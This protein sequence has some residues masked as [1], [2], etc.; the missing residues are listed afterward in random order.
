MNDL[1]TA[2]MTKCAGSALSTAVGGRIFEGEAPDG[3]AF[4]YVVFMIVAGSPNDNFTDLI[5]EIM[6]QFSL[7]SISKGLTEIT[8]I[9]ENLK[10]LFDYCALS[11]SG[12][13]HIGMLR[14]SMT[15]MIADVTTPSGTES[16]RHWSVDYLV[17]TEK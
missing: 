5:D 14:Q 4:P 16:M 1:L 8:G 13:S 6:I 2:I 12:Y 7:Y 3:A 15:T 11:I 10:T 17:R 9:Y